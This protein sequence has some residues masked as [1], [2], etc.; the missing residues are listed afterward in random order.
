MTANGLSDQVIVEHVR[1]NG[2]VQPLSTQDL[3]VLKQRGVSDAV[4]NA[5]QQSPLA[6]S[7]GRDLP[8]ATYPVYI[9]RPYCPP[10]IYYVRPWGRHHHCPPGVSWHFEF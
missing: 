8:P 4:I 7:S 5:M 6:V 2:V 1:A 10:P 3:I 9:E